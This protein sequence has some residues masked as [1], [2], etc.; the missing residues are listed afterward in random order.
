MDAERPDGFPTVLH[1]L[2][3]LPL[4]GQVIRAL[5]TDADLDLATLSAPCSRS[6]AAALIRLADVAE[7]VAS[8]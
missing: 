5:I 4:D 7:G 1:A 8:L 2:L 6:L 3:M